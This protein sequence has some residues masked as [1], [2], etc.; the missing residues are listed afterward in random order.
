MLMSC[1]FLSSPFRA[2]LRSASRSGAPVTLASTAQR[3]E[4]TANNHSEYPLHWL[5]AERRA[6]GR[7]K[8]VAVAIN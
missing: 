2:V 5:P 7:E 8:Y 3:C 1:N 6:R 4:P